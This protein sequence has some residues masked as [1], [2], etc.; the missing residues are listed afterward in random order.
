MPWLVHE[1]TLRDCSEKLN[2]AKLKRGNS[3]ECQRGI[4]D[5]FIEAAATTG[6]SSI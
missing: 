5:I 4:P 1:C 6:A 3:G 2:A